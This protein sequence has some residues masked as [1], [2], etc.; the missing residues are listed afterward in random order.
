MDLGQDLSDSAVPCSDFSVCDSLRPLQS[1]D[2]IYPSKARTM[3]N[4]SDASLSNAICTNVEQRVC[5]KSDVQS[6]VCENNSAYTVCHAIDGSRWLPKS[7]YTDCVTYDEVRKK[8]IADDCKYRNRKLQDLVLNC[9]NVWKRQMEYKLSQQS[10][11]ECCQ[12]KNTGR[13]RSTCS[14]IAEEEEDCLNEGKFP[15]SV[16][17]N[18]TKCLEKRSVCRTPSSKLIETVTVCEIP[19]NTI[20][21]CV[22]QTC[23]S[24][25]EDPMECLKG[26]CNKNLKMLSVCQT[27]PSKLDENATICKSVSFSVARDRFEKMQTCKS[28]FE[29]SV[30]CP[31]DTTMYETAF[32]NSEELTEVTRVCKKFVTEESPKDITVCRRMFGEPKG[33]PEEVIVGEAL[34]DAEEAPKE[35]ICRKISDSNFVNQGND[36]RVFLNDAKD[37]ANAKENA[38]NSNLNKLQKKNNENAKRVTIQ[39]D[40]NVAF[41]NFTGE[42]C[43]N[44][45]KQDEQNKE[46]VSNNLSKITTASV[47]PVED[48]FSKSS[49]KIIY[50][51]TL[52]QTQV[53][54]HPNLVSNLNEKETSNAFVNK[55]KTT[56]HL[57]FNQHMRNNS[58]QPNKDPNAQN[59]ASNKID[60]SIERKTQEELKEEE[61]E[62]NQDISKERRTTEEKR[63]SFLNRS[64]KRLTDMIKLG[65][66]KIKERTEI[67]KDIPKKIIADDKMKDVGK[68]D[69]IF[70]KDKITMPVRYRFK[71]RGKL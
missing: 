10:S 35:T 26:K 9:N 17:N 65:R 48:S 25:F 70:E 18:N 39:L 50:S 62:E 41:N 68:S 63:D 27:F 54:N 49:S 32:G 15:E 46:T 36:K 14:C 37:N 11:E 23:E 1:W 59:S 19:F 43:A 12:R 7:I 60:Q 40:N 20:G 71:G 5:D 69:I 28:T 66:M 51:I 4:A 31:K 64:V 21:E 16:C 57:A 56:I 61:E 29:N 52:P 38:N 22:E 67:A 53:Y 24:M 34:P 30:K 44:D 6:N 55:R 13:Q 47:E 33:P 2:T 8:R 42:K 58:Q 45:T 3:L